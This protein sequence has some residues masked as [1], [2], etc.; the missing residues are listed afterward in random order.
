M[1]L[2]KMVESVMLLHTKVLRPKHKKINIPIQLS[3]IGHYPNKTKR[4]QLM[5]FFFESLN[6]ALYGGMLNDK[7][8][9][10]K[11][12]DDNGGVKPDIVD[13]IKKIHW[14]CKSSVS[15]DALEIDESQFRKYEYDQYRM[16]KRRFFYSIYRHSLRGIQ[17]EKRTEEQ[18]VRE[19]S[20]KTNFSVVL[21]ISI[22]IAL[23][24]IRGNSLVSSYMDK[25]TSWNDC[26]SIRSPTTN[27]F[28]TD[29]E[30]ILVD[31]GLSQQE[32]IIERYLSPSNFIVNGER[33][34][35]FP[36]VRIYDKNYRQW[37]Q[38][39]IIDYEREM[40]RFD[41]EGIKALPIFS[42]NEELEPLPF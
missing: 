25:Q 27:R 14:E 30:N 29:P 16:P 31:I 5:G 13:K 26:F 18:I 33:I 6:H 15:G 42:E 38:K 21:P 4:G 36:I 2:E 40:E 20:E 3:F 28:L 22:L 41:D 8:Y 35:Q 37:A 11:L 7:K 39:F 17:K 23:S 12:N 1:R 10:S 24:K 9:D 34:R 19:L 32:F